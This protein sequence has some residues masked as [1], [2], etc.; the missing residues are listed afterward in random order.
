MVKVIKA[1]FMRLMMFIINVVYRV[2]YLVAYHA[3]HFYVGRRRFRASAVL[4]LLHFGCPSRPPDG[5]T[6]KGLGQCLQRNFVGDALPV[7]SVRKG[8]SGIF[9]LQ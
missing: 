9:K 7:W 1:H 3:Q 8:K 2:V 4:L 5:V 6:G